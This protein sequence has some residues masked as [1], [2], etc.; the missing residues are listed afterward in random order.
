MCLQN[1]FFA[2]ITLNGFLY[3]MLLK[4]AWR[5][6]FRNKRRTLI[7]LMMI[8][9][10][11]VLATFMSAMRFGIMDAQVENVVGGFKGYA[12]ICDTGYVKE[13]ILDR[14][15]VYNDSI[16]NAL[17]KNED[18]LAYS[19]R[20]VGG[21]SMESGGKF[22][23]V[24][25]VGV[26]PE[27]EDQVTHLQERVVKGR[28]LSN[29]GEVVLGTDLAK[30]LK[31]DVDSVV[32]VTGGGYHGN[33][34][35]LLLKVVGLVKLPNIQEN[36]RTGFITMDEAIDGFA[37]G[38]LVSNIVISF[39]DNNHAIE[40]VDKMKLDYSKNIGVYSWAEMDEPLFMLVSINDSVNII[41]SGILYFIISFGLF[42]TILMMLSERKNEFGV[43]VSIGMSKQKLGLLV[44][45]ENVLMGI[46]GTA[47]GFLIAIP[48][49][50]Y[51]H[52]YP[53]ELTGAEA[54]GMMKNGFEPILSVSNDASIFIWQAVT[55][56]C[57]SIFFSLYPILKIRSM[58][59]HKAMKS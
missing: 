55:V 36:K 57:M 10:A 28:Y 3:N 46:I 17:L 39:V 40:I 29:S 21:G 35:N 1:I 53:V 18:I 49:V 38:G 54:E 16:K 15:I 2:S 8:Q 9:F 12:S 14:A 22:K 5:N 32:F 24:S 50:N 51:M 44:F 19:P 58:N 42:G 20:I 31:V 59:E 6:I 48:L 41:I 11:V 7:T 34:A 37:T 4:L 25:I 33:S 30:R 43:L 52:F 26:I 47:I 23:V 45:I 13:P 27:L 56:L